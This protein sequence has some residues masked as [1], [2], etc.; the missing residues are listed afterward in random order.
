MDEI[1][2]Y[3]NE[4]DTSVFLY[5]NGLHNSFWD[6][7]MTIYSNRFVWIPFY[8][9]FL[10]VMLRNM[11]LKVTITCLLIIAAIIFVCDQTA[12]TI[13]KPMVARMRPSNLDNPIAPMV[14]VVFGYRGGRYGF[15]SS[16]AANAWSMAFF[17]MYLAK[18][19]KLTT[20]L[21]TWAF[22]MSY[23]RVYLGVHYP[24]DLLVGMFIGFIT[25]TVSFYAFRHFAKG[26]TDYFDPKFGP[27]RHSF[28]PIL[29]GVG[30]VGIMLV[31]SGAMSYIQH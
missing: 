22:V 23:S 3:L 18:R 20:F 29:A 28:V 9:S 26:Y 8:A 19:S 4:I 25:A 15:P 16:H 13:L 27:L 10:Y 5:F 6:Y 14:H 17:A 30:S 11:P 31:I 21:F 12:S 1:I 7:F 2:R 24:G